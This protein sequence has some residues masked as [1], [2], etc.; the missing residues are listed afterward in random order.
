MLSVSRDGTMTEIG[1]VGR[2][3]M[4]GLP[5]FSGAKTS[6]RRACWQAPG[7]AYRMD[8]G[9]LRRETRSGGALADAL[10]LYTQ[11]VFTQVT[12]VEGDEFDLT[13]EWLA[14]ARRARAGITEVAGALQCA[15]LMR[16]AR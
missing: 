3:R 13:H 15:G 16:Y 6:A 10:H 4:V 9:L 1:T 7:T 8:A 5:A 14:D 11:A 12:R 2:E